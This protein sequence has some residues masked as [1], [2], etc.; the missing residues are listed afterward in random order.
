MIYITVMNTTL[1]SSST[2]Y[3]V[4]GSLVYLTLAF[5]RIRRSW[6]GRSVHHMRHV[7]ALMN[8]WLGT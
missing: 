4:H 2:S 1:L 7:C 6:T 8:D 3:D 5:G